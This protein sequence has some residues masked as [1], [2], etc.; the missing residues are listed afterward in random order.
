MEVDGLDDFGISIRWL[1]LALLGSEILGI[2]RNP[3]LV[4]GLNP[5]EENCR[6]IG[7][8]PQTFGL[9]K[10]VFI[11][12]SHL[13]PKLF[14]DG[15]PTFIPRNSLYWVYI[16]TVKIILKAKNISASGS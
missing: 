4:G 7:S 3:Y 13:W 8:F 1:F 16:T 12:N 2:L 14:G 6:Q 10:T 11:W 5:F 9:K 15:H